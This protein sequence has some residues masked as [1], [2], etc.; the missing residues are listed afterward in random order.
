MMAWRRDSLF[1][2][3]HN[4][5]P[6]EVHTYLGPKDPHAPWHRERQKQSN[7]CQNG[8]VIHTHLGV[9]PYEW[10]LRFTHVVCESWELICISYIPYLI[11]WSMCPVCTG[12]LNMV[13][14]GHKI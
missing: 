13:R 7:K 5:S 1:G 6:L 4:R 11:P 3:G 10:A 9:A 2:V 14:V 8:K 12:G